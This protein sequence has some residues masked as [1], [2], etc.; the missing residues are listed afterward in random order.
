M[1]EKLIFPGVLTIVLISFLPPVFAREISGQAIGFACNGCHGT[2]GE[3]ASPGIPR[4]KNRS[5]KKLETA[6]LNF[7]YNR[8][9]SAVMGRI[10]KGYSDAELKSVAEYFSQL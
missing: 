7:K 6:L 5:A 9:P 3:L 4:L 1:T 8:K 10:S 2:D